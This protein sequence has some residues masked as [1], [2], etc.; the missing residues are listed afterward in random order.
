MFGVEDRDST[1]IVLLAGFVFASWY[2]FIMGG[3]YILKSEAPSVAIV[4]Q[5]EQNTVEAQIKSLNSVSDSDTT[6]SIEQ[7]LNATDLSDLDKE[8]TDIENSL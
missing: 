7:E 2:I 3:H 6:T 8:L 5:Q 4:S 1:L